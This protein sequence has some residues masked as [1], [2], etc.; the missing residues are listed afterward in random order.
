MALEIN[1]RALQRVDVDGTDHWWAGDLGDADDPS[2]TVH[3]MQ[4]YDEFIVAY[5]SPRLP[6]NLSG[7]IPPA[8]LSRPPLLHAIVLDGQGVGFWRRVAVK[9]GFEIE[10][11][12]ARDL[13]AREQRA[14]RAA[15]DRYAEFLAQPVTLMS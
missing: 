8:A 1:G 13:S 5:R 7:L 12:L 10:T 14:L 15:V 6:I 2:P 11:K 9:S 4:G 3:L